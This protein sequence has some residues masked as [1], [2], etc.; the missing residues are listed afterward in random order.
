M[1][2]SLL[3]LA[4]VLASPAQAAMVAQPLDYTVAGTKLQ[5]MLVYDDA[6]A[7]PRPGLV[8]AP[9][10][11]G[12]TPASVALAKQIAGKDYVILVADL[13]GTGVR[14]GNGGEAGALVGKLYADR[15]LLRARING[16]LTQ[17]KAQQGKAPLDGRHWGAI[18]FCFGGT[19][20][21]DL[22]RSGAA[23]AGVVSFHGGLKGD[24]AFKDDIKAR[25]LVLHGADDAYESAEEIAAFQ[26]EMRQAKADW[27]FVSYGGAVHCFAIPTATGAAAGCQYDERTARRAF[28]HM[29]AFFTEAF[30]P[31]Q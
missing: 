5:G 16:A 30:A 14:P 26:Q 27:Q 22:A 3:A 13:Y 1:R 17:L 6:V 12:V 19:S 11:F 31:G 15:A 8:M 21:L 25:V 9:D 10:W 28:A 20:V 4:M 23:V 2:T 24:P 7:T 18:G 29:R